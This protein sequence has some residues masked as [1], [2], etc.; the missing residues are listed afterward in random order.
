[1]IYLAKQIMP[2]VKISTVSTKKAAE[3]LGCNIKEMRAIIKAGMV[4]AFKS[5][6]HW[7][8]NLVSLLKFKYGMGGNK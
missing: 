7:V 8:I 3:I 6:G 2:D 1:M 5:K 4:D